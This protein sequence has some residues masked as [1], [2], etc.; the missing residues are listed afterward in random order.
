M[1]GDGMIDD[2]CYDICVPVD[3]SKRKRRCGRIPHRV[4]G[5]GED[6]KSV[7]CVY[8]LRAILSWGGGPREGWRRFVSW[9]WRL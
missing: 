2:R 7:G 6:T 4:F 9:E 5:A 1:G 8:S 3:G